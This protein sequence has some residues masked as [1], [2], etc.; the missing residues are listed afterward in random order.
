LEAAINS[1]DAILKANIGSYSPE[2]IQP[3]KAKI[4]NLTYSSLGKDSSGR[5]RVYEGD[6]LA[7]SFSGGSGEVSVTCADLTLISLQSGLHPKANS[8]LF[9]IPVVSAATNS[10]LVITD[11]NTTSSASFPISILKPEVFGTKTEDIK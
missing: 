2:D 3:F 9:R 1:L 7:I 10:A 6:T 8:R 4:K 5:L 11:S